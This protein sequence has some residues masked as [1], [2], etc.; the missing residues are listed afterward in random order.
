M[1]DG[2]NILLITTDTQ[3]WDTVACMGAPHAISPNTDRL[4]AEGV[5]FDQSHTSSPVCMPCRCSIITGTHTPV[6]GCVENGVARFTHL[7]V[8]TNFLKERGYLTI[9]EGKTH[10]GPIPESFDIIGPTDGAGGDGERDGDICHD[11]IYRD[12][13]ER[14]PGHLW[15]DRRTTEA[16]IREM[17]AAAKGDAPFFVFCS[18]VAPHEPF[19]PPARQM[20]SHRDIEIKPLNAREGEWES[21]PQYMRDAL[22]LVG[23]NMK[24][25]PSFEDDGA[26]ELVDE[27]RRLYYA[28]SAFCD[29]ELG[30]LM[31]FLDA[32]GLRENTLVIYT[33]D[34]GTQLYDHGFS[35][36]HCYYD[37]T[38]RVP[39]V[40]SQPGTLPQG[41]RR[42]FAI[43]NDLAATILGAAGTSCPTM[44]AF[45]LY[46]PLVNGEANPRRCAV[47]ALYEGCA[48]ATKRW[49]LDFFMEEGRGRLFDRLND[50][51][52]QVDLFDSADYGDVRSA[53]VEALL[54]WRSGVRD[55]HS[56]QS[57]TSGGGP[58]AQVVSR[59]TREMTG[60][61][62]EQ[63]LND[64]A[65]AID[66]R[67]G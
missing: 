7:P 30:R 60:L 12:Q 1:S 2:P 40:M 17:E 41:E 27:R 63:R 10:F 55:V 51:V 37:E 61:G 13:T 33:S 34:H 31:D 53:M 29:E 25:H 46:T 16:T 66:A 64:A 22:G 47:S 20:A 8:F 58:V 6:H 5:L 9:M 43:S 24:M 19:D 62:S 15:R 49:K 52:E 26:R 4:A 38:W 11:P 56:L 28:H 32:S 54:N 59:H 48:L 39:L 36:K 57:R 18:I 14:R 35:N 50:P 23:H 21:H 42:D 45:D 67:W 44:Q 65:E 3:R